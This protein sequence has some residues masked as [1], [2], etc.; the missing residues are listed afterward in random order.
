MDERKFSAQLQ[1]IVNIHTQEVY[2]FEVLSR[3]DDPINIEEF[4]KRVHPS[5]GA[6]ISIKVLKDV[7][8]AFAKDPKVIQFNISPTQLLYPTTINKLCNIL[9]G[10]YPSSFIICEL[11]EMGDIDVHHLADVMCALVEK[12]LKFSLDDFGVGNN[13]FERLWKLPV[14]Q[15][16]VDRQFVADIHHCKKQQLLVS[17]L[18]ELSEMF[19]VQVV[20]EGVETLTHHATLQQLGVSFAQGY[21]YKRPFPLFDLQSGIGHDR[22]LWDHLGNLDAIK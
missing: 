19:D 17:H 12:G 22:I 20:C 9:S 10:S 21:L 3:C 11:T 16:K 7:M 14:S 15:L 18:L 1:P 8:H 5:E 13:G 6:S 4:F 2:S